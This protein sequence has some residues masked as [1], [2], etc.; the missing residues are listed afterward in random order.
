MEENE[1]S[2]AIIGA[3][4]EVHKQIGPGLLES[5]YEAALAFELR[6]Q[7]YKV[8]TQVPLVVNYKGEDLGKGYI[9]DM[10]VNNLVLLELKSVAEQAPVFYLQTLTYL[11]HSNLKLGLL[12]N[13]NV[14]TMKNGIHRIVNKL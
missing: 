11:K 9:A 7:G 4:I 10:I 6:L 5:S 1:L 12:I 3:C 14:V 8:Q 2:Y 13:F